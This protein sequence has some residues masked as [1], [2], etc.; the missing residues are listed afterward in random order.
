MDN[1]PPQTLCAQVTRGPRSKTLGRH[2]F[3]KPFEPALQRCTLRCCPF[4]ERCA[5]R[6]AVC[7]GTSA[8]VATGDK[9]PGRQMFAEAYH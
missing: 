6:A 7:A 2:T 8:V 9:V 3:R 4:I 5:K 1:L